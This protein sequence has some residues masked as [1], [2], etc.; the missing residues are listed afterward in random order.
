MHPPTMASWRA[1]Y[2][3]ERSGRPYES[4]S[5]PYEAT[6]DPRSLRRA[7]Y[8]LDELKFACVPLSRPPS[9]TLLRLAKGVSSFRPILQR[10]LKSRLDAIE[11]SHHRVISFQS[12]IRLARAPLVAEGKCASTGSHAQTAGPGDNLKSHKNAETLNKLATPRLRLLPRGRPR[13][14]T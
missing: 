11:N 7:S 10:R 8:A 14:I 13:R 2:R 1:I 3:V 6:H 12:P 5:I 9:C 4:T